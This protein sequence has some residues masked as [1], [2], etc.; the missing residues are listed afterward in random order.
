MRIN[1]KSYHFFRINWQK[2]NIKFYSSTQY[3]F[4]VNRCERRIFASNKKRIVRDCL[5]QCKMPDPRFLVD[6]IGVGGG[7]YSNEGCVK[8]AVKKVIL[9]TFFSCMH[10]ISKIWIY[11]TDQFTLGINKYK[12][13]PNRSRA[14]FYHYIKR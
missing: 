3:D 2:G 1:E 5:N 7:R 6:F 4:H 11:H 8:L 14:V 12:L 9:Q 10:K 13:S